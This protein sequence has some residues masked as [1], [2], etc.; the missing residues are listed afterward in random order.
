[1]QILVIRSEPGASETI[2]RLQAASYET[3]KSPVLAI[4]SNPEVDIPDLSEIEAL[5]FT[6]ANGVRAFAQRT[7]SR[8]HTAWCVGPAT[9]AAAR[10]AGFK[11][12][13]QSSG[14]ATD[15]ADYIINRTPPTGK[16][17]L[18]IANAEA[19]GHLRKR[20][21]N[22]GFT[23]VFC[24][25]YRMTRA[26]HLS[27]TALETLISQ[28]PTLVL[29]HSEKGALAFSELISSLTPQNCTGVAISHQAAEPLSG[30]A[31]KQ[32]NIADRP[33]EDSLMET[34]QMTVA[35]LST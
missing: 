14:N 6:S 34:L 13:E 25:L 8:D 23:I 24:P 15:L 32:I 2:A 12:V 19:K 20:L 22:A 18:H 17:M 28:A 30:S 27:D 3:I 11:R 21:T 5:I 35:T 29:I 10:E 26:I 16:P 31:L 7:E 4:A 1:P 33:D 9:A